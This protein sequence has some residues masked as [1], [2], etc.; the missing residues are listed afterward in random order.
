MGKFYNNN[1]GMNFSLAYYKN[2]G[3]ILNFR[4]KEDTEINGKR[5]IEYF[6]I[7][8]VKEISLKTVYPGLVIGIG[9]PH[10]VSEEDNS[11]D[12]KLGFYFDYTTGIP[13]IPGSTV[14]GILK[15]VFPK[16][17]DKENVK[18]KKLSYINGILGRSN[19]ITE[20]N[21]EK[22]FEKGNIFFDAYISSVPEDGKIFA[23][24]Y[25][26]PHL[27]KLKNPIPI[28]FLKIAPGVT[29]T[30]QF[31]LKDTIFENG[32]KITINEKLKI[33]KRILIDFG[34]GAKRNVGYGTL[35]F[36]NLKIKDGKRK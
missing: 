10:P 26:S 28:K 36:F 23:E 19:I 30:F 6:K 27:E 7:D 25:I 35:M 3:D 4:L 22:M 21:W 32:E 5:Y 33:F 29:F 31:K 18:N 9:Y 20:N 1:F 15:S 14:K 11:E 2:K 13:V 24:D 12:F 8:E 16:K 34:I 17:Y